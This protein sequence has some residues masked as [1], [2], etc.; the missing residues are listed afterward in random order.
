[1]A[2]SGFKGIGPNKLGTSPLK[3]TAAQNKAKKSESIKK[4]LKSRGKD[5][6]GSDARLGK[7]HGIIGAINE[8]VKNFRENTMTSE[9]RDAFKKN[10]I[11]D[12]SEVNPSYAELKAKAGRRIRKFF[13]EAET[14]IKP[15]SKKKK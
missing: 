7:G 8:G 5:L 6:I 9:G 3:Q 12:I 10:V 15:Q 14:P 2:Y 13:G 4:R 1:M 11:K